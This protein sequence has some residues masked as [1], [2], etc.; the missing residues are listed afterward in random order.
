MA[1]NNPPVH[2]S[3]GEEVLQSRSRRNIRVLAEQSQPG[4]ADPS[5]HHV[6]TAVENDRSRVR[7]EPELRLTTQSEWRDRL[8]SGKHFLQSGTQIGQEESA[9]SEELLLES[10]SQFLRPVQLLAALH[11]V[12]SAVLAEVENNTDSGQ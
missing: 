3:I 12:R 4:L 10:H 7:G 9:Q 2:R 5:G 11:S 1:C 8:T 6:G